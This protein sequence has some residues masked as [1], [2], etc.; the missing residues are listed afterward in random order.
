[1]SGGSYDYL[2]RDVTPEEVLGRYRDL[3]DMAEALD[4][5]APDAARETR[6]L[7]SSDGSSLADAVRAVTERL[8]PL[9]WQVER[10]ESADGNEAQTLKAVDAYR[11]LP[12]LDRH[13]LDGSPNHVRLT[14][15]D[16]LIYF[17]RMRGDLAPTTTWLDQVES[18]TLAVAYR[19]IHLRFLEVH[20]EEALNT[21][22]E[23]LELRRAEGR[24]ERGGEQ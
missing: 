2:G 13:L 4:R 24:R 5:I 8:S 17:R 15:E 6:L 21:V 3:R 11:A 16:G 23:A 7:L 18:R 14:G 20:L 10:W 22:R 9:W 19:L 1:V 12:P